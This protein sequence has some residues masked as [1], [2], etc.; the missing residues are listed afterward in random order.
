MSCYQ[1]LDLSAILDQDFGNQDL[2]LDDQ[3]GSVSRMDFDD[4]VEIITELSE[5]IFNPNLPNPAVPLL[6]HQASTSSDSIMGLNGS[7]ES[8]DEV[9]EWFED[10]SCFGP[11]SLDCLNEESGNQ[12]S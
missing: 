5:E 8:L 1:V 6:D 7:A 2:P 9:F 3:D 12:R 10:L 4:S 11:S